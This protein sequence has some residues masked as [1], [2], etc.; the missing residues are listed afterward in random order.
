MAHLVACH[1]ERA[2]GFAKGFG[3]ESFLTGVEIEI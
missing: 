3:D 2:V 1:G